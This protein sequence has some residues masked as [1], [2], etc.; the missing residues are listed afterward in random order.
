V[1]GT[2]I[3]ELISHQQGIAKDQIYHVSL[4]PCFDKKLEASRPEFENE[5]D[6]VVTTKEIVQLLLDKGMSFD[7]LPE[8]DDIEDAS[9]APQNWPVQDQYMSHAG[10]SS[11]GYMDYALQAVRERV[12]GEPTR[13]EV[14]AGRNADVVEYRVVRETDGSHVGT[15]GRVYGFRNIQ[16]LVRKLKT[17]K[18]GGLRARRAGGTASTSATAG[19]STWDYVEVMACPGGCINGGGQITHPDNISQREWLAHQETLYNSIQQVP[20]TSARVDRWLSQ[21]WHGDLESLTA[22]SYQAV[23]V[24]DPTALSVGT[25]W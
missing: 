18:A 16:N 17:P 8:A 11:G 9:V 5:V 3:K 2:L 20:V 15:V 23:E 1:T 6:C 21:L 13:V 19:P 10:T 4:M 24:Q 22:A 14:V 12:G 7:A 25:R